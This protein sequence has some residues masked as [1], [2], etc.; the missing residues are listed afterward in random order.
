MHTRV[1]L[2]I[3]GTFLSISFVLN[4]RKKLDGYKFP[5]YSTPFCPRN[6]SE[7][8]NRSTDLNCNET[9]GYTCLPNEKLTELLEFCYIEPWIWIQEG[10]CLY[11]ERKGSYVDSYSC[12]HFIQ[13]CHNTSY[14]SIRIFE[15][16]ACI[17]LG[18][19]C[20][21]AEQ[22]CKS[23]PKTTQHPITIEHGKIDL[24]WVVLLIG[25]M[26]FMSCFS[27]LMLYLY[28]KK[29]VC[30]QR[31][32]KESEMDLEQITPLKNEESQIY[33][34]IFEQWK[35]EDSCFISTK[36]S[37]KVEKYIKSENLV[38]VAG[39]SG[40]GKSAIIQH[41]AL[42]YREQGWTVKRVKEEE[43]IVR[44]YSS[45]RFQKDKTI[46]VLDDPLGKEFLDERFNKS[47]HTYG[48]KF[49]VSCRS[50]SRL[51]S[52]FVNQSSIVNLDDIKLSADEKRQI[53]TKYSSDMNLSEG[54]YK[55]IFKVDKYFPLLC[56]FLSTK[57]E[58]R[59]KGREKISP[60]FIASEQ[61]HDSIVQLLLE[62]GAD[63]N[64]C[65]KDGVSPLYIACQNG[66]ESTVQL[67]LK[68]G[69]DID[70]CPNN[71]ASPLI[72]AC[73]NG[74]GSTVQLLLENGAK[75]SCPKNG[76][77]PLIMACKN[78]DDS[79]VKCLL[80][81]GADINLCTKD[82]RSPSYIAHQYGHQSTVRLLSKLERT[83]IYVQ[84]TEPVLSL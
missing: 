48:E 6:E 56:K 60:L 15:N 55:A 33:E 7:W 26:V 39:H 8:Q 19:G 3:F 46:F 62:N 30:Q 17:S 75:D 1:R 32:Y 43:D 52:Y 41:T 59:D 14:Q 25:T 77:S 37:K 49:L 57:E 44:E 72:I 2:V 23:S 81:N 64:L 42:K 76:V 40:S 63:I 84:R 70:L 65:T 54:V 68:Y 82:G 22:S 83:S 24:I 11:L 74:H 45:S 80:E 16:P 79:I 28:R 66:Y 12:L 13:G 27:I 50:H 35:K 20:F 47:L 36:A 31:H 78:G 34:A 21:L 67:L 71:G 58:D 73:Q 51:T 69:A 10:Y 38:I 18:N 9:N 53:W 4:E 29:R 5:V 61:G